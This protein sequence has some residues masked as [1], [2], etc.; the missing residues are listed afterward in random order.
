[1]Q[2]CPSPTLFFEML[3][4]LLEFLL[5]DGENK[6][7]DTALVKEGIGELKYTDDG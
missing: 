4:Y 2:L 1:M 3:L 7:C 5:Q 6:N